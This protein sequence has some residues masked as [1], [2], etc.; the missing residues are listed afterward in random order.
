[1]KNKYIILLVFFKLHGQQ[2][3]L[4][5]GIGPTWGS[6]D[7]IQEEQ[8]IN[9]QDFLR[10]TNFKINNA[11]GYSANVFGEYYYN[12]WFSLFFNGRY[13]E[14]N[15][16]YGSIQTI[17]INK[18]SKDNDIL[19]DIDFTPKITAKGVLICNQTNLWKNKNKNRL[20]NILVG[21]NYH[22]DK[23]ISKWE[24]DFGIADSK[25]TGFVAGLELIST[26][27]NFDLF[28][29]NFFY[30]DKRI[31]ESTR[32][33]LLGQ[34]PAKIDYILLTNALCLGGVFKIY[35]KFHFLPFFC[36][37]Y[38]KN[39]N[40]GNIIF[41]DNDKNKFINPKI[42]LSKSNQF[43]TMFNICYYF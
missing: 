39:A 12:K 19:S 32:N 26:Y 5:G 1:M 37:V 28:L 38:S 6:S 7:F 21:Y 41:P 30:P 14:A 43:Y 9:E 22:K 27:K 3:F 10:Q 33:S 25:Y 18:F 29:T 2:T 23:L 31:T 40:T 35:K 4:A 15:N 20:A 36:W 34:T 24:D 11:K 42:C 8:Y 13:S 17:K 16:G